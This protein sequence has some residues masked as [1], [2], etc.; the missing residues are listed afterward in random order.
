MKFMGL[1]RF[2]EKTKFMVLMKFAELWLVKSSIRNCAYCF[3]GSLGE[4]SVFNFR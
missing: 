3:V 1:I 4:S 2:A